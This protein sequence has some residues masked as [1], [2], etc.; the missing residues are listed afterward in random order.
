[1]AENSKAS[2]VAGWR[3]GGGCR[4]RKSFIEKI[5][6]ITKTWKEIWKARRRRKMKAVALAANRRKVKMWRRNG[7]K[8]MAWR[9]YQ[10]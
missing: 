4:K 5:V 2:A 3:S 7:W 8:S 1:V 6:E 9:K 10:K